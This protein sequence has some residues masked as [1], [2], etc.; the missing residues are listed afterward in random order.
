ANAQGTL[1]LI[2]GA[3]DQSFVVP[4]GAKL[5]RMTL[6]SANTTMSFAAGASASLTGDFTL[7]AGTFTSSSGTLTV[8]AIGSPSTFTIS[9][10][11]FNHNSGTV[12]F[13]NSDSYAITVDANQAFNNVTVNMF[14]G[15]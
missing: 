2:D 1:L 4:S 11:T 14:P 6:N 13:G 3:G 5:P 12:Q 8:T 15:T 9:G 10:G 7:Q